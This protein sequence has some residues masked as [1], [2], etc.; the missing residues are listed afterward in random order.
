MNP[1][2]L[3]AFHAGNPELFRVTILSIEASLRRQI[4]HY[5]RANRDE[6]DD[7]YSETCERI[8]E[9]RTE[10]HGDGPVG[11]WARVLCERTC[12][13]H[14]R[15]DALAI[16]RAQ[17]FDT[18]PRITAQAGSEDDRRALAEHVQSI[19]DDIADAINTLPPRSRA[20][21]IA[22]VYLDE[23]AAEIARRFRIKPSSVWTALWLARKLLREPLMRIMRHR[24]QTPT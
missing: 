20:M 18:L 5:A 14:F 21:M 15:R 11:A 3:A 12:M 4:A 2:D 13:D 24:S 9:R 6:A 22:N 19:D 17:L 8:F 7:L 1:S 23:S 16:R 10:Y